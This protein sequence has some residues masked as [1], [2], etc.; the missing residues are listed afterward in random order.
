MIRRDLFKNPQN[1]LEQGAQAAPHAHEG[2]RTAQEEAV[3]ACPHCK[4]L[5]F[6]KDAARSLYVCECGHHVRDLRPQGAGRSP[7]ANPQT[8][9][10]G[11]QRVG[12]N[13]HHVAQRDQLRQQVRVHQAVVNPYARLWHDLTNQREHGVAILCPMSYGK[14]KAVAAIAGIERQD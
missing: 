4:R 13:Q 9:G 2:E 6:E 8:P 14:G 10:H 7:A 1:Q 3:L 12:R 11:G 5:L